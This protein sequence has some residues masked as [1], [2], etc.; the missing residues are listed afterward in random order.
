[1]NPLEEKILNF[2]EYIKH[3]LVLIN[4]TDDIEQIQAEK[5]VHILKYKY[6]VRKFL[7]M[8]FT[9]SDIICAY[10][11]EVVVIRLEND[12]SGEW[13]KPRDLRLTLFKEIWDKFNGYKY[14]EFD[15]IFTDFH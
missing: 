5:I 15:K 12:Y 7:T 2:Y 9:M 8:V 10:P 1:M 14:M 6:G 13:V 11:Y 4:F 3:D